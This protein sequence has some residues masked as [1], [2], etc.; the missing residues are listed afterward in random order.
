MVSQGEFFIAYNELELNNVSS[1][2]MSINTHERKVVT[3]PYH[4][5]QSLEKVLEDYDA[6]VYANKN[7]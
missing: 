1:F 6:K 4:I 5:I 2:Y 3:G 7:K